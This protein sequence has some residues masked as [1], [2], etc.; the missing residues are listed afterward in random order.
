MFV[1]VID[2]CWSRV[3]HISLCYSLL[4]RLLSWLHNSSL[5]LGK[6][7]KFQPRFSIDLFWTPPVKPHRRKWWRWPVRAAKPSC[8]AAI[9]LFFNQSPGK[10][11]PR[12]FKCSP[13]LHGYWLFK[14][15]GSWTTYGVL[16]HA[17][18]WQHYW[19]RWM[20]LY[21]CKKCALKVIRCYTS[22]GQLKLHFV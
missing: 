15:V 21:L 16:S 19:F 5:P 14:L 2:T 22:D 1:V 8:Q 7:N 3:L 13:V 17:F 12:V 6:R 20:I 11:T 10:V 9:F 18:N 4:R